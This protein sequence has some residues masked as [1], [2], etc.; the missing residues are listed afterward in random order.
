[1]TLLA[2]HQASLHVHYRLAEFEIPI[3]DTE[4]PPSPRAQGSRGGCEGQSQVLRYLILKFPGGSVALKGDGDRLLIPEL[5]EQLHC[6]V[7]VIEI[8][9]IDAL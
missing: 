4:L 5:L 9:A 8:I 1:M 3:A 7:K 2:L 6:L